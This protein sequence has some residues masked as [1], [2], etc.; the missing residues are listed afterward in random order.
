LEAGNYANTL[1]FISFN[2]SSRAATSGVGKTDDTLCSNHIF[3]NTNVEELCA[4][5]GM[6]EVYHLA[7][8]HYLYP[9]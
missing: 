4:A 2:L 6:A 5:V 3:F 9:P 1:G 7:D 8:M